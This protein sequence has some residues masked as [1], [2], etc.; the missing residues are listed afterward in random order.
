LE[1]GTIDKI[2]SQT[3]QCGTSCQE[4]SIYHV[5]SKEYKRKYPLV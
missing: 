2:P 4:F 1:F 3:K 5:Y